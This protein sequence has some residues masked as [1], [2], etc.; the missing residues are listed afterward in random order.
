MNL[1]KF[2]KDIDSVI[3]AFQ[4]DAFSV[5]QYN[6]KVDVDAVCDLI[7][8]AVDLFNNIREKANGCAETGNIKPYFRKLV[9]EAVIGVEDLNRKLSELVSSAKE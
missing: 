9:E 1:R 7:E 3:G 2:K 5:L 6:K 4:E 8:K